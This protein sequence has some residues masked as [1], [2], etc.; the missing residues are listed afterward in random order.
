M[1]DGGSRE[2]LEIQGDADIGG[3]QR[4]FPKRLLI[5]ESS[6][7]AREGALKERLK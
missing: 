6:V 4:I 1:A 3:Y 5:S 2:T 7:R